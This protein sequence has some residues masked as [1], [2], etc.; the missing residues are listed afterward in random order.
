M[1]TI[2]APGPISTHFA[3]VIDFIEYMYDSRLSINS[4]ENR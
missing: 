2:L 1:M 3:Y 4:I